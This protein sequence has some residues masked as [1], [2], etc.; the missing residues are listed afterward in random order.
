MGT[1]F[2][3]LPVEIHKKI[4]DHLFGKMPPISQLP[5]TQ[6]TLRHVRQKSLS[7]L[8]LICSLWCLLVQSRI[9]C[10]R[11]FLPGYGSCQL[12]NNS[13]SRSRAA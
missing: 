2:V 7:N 12:S 3:D 6:S 10:H 13:K 9:Y 1:K 5:Q 8:A 4:L 11:K